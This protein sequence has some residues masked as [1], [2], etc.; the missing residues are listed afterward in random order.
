[1]RILFFVLSTPELIM[2]SPPI[3]VVSVATAAMQ[4]GH[5]VKIVEFTADADTESMV[6]DAV[7]AFLPDAIGIAVRN[8]DDQGMSG[9]R[10]LIDPQKEVAACCRAVS[11]VPIILGGPGYSM[12]PERLLEWVDADIGIHG[13]GEAALPAVLDCLQ[14]GVDVH[15]FVNFGGC[16]TP[17]S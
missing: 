17:S 3:G 13:D 2:P 12:Y 14:Q 11:K 15:R 8:I 1:M 16:G 10:I 9:A 5:N 7:A 6:Q 4:K